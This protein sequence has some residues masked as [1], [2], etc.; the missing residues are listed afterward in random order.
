MILSPDPPH[1]TD[2][3][4]SG[5]PLIAL[6]GVSKVYRTAE[7]EVAALRPIDFAVER[8][9]FFVIVGPSGCGKS[10]L[11]K[12]IAGLT[13][14]SAGEITVEGKRVT[15]PHGGVG[16]VFQSPLLMEWRRVLAN[17]L[18]PAEVKRLDTAK[19]RERALELIA[20]AGLKGFENKYPFELSGGMQQRV[21]ICRALLN[22]PQ[23]VLMDEPF[24]A[25]DAMTRERMNL[26]LQRI[27]RKTGKT[28]LLITHSIPEAVFLGDRVLVM[29]ER[30]GG[31]AA[32][33]DIDLPRPRTPQTMADP[34][35]TAHAA[36]IRKHFQSAAEAG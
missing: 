19:A 7:G 1:R 8:G 24:A 5:A 9:E 27:Q 25:L 30:P 36:A 4:G 20:L 21:A 29:S 34:R 22:D 6:A 12:M 26:E 32:V 14:P 10:T 15:R 18:L 13:A 28:I 11:L 35:F 17:V 31:V 2:R 16:I 3:Q 33:Y 23:I